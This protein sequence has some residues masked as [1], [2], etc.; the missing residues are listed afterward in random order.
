VSRIVAL[1]ALVALATLALLAALSLTAPT[2]VLPAP[3]DAPPPERVTTQ[4][5]GSQDGGGLDAFD[6]IQVQHALGR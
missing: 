1:G 4:A 6:A 5:T 2:P 3:P